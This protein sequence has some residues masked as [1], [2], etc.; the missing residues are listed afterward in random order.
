MYVVSCVKSCVKSNE[1][2]QASFEMI[3]LFPS[4]KN[5]LKG[6]HENF[7]KWS[8][9]FAGSALDNSDVCYTYEYTNYNIQGVF[10][11]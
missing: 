1:N 4:N 11:F 9:V 7:Q 3:F 8:M 10:F 5:H 6:R 2:K